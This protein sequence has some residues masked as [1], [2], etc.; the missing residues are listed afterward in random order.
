VTTTAA[1]GAGRAV[2]LLIDTSGSTVLQGFA[3]ASEQALPLLMD[4]AAAVGG[5]RV[6]L[7]GYGS[8]AQVL[9]RLAVAAD[10]QVIP[11]L[12]VSGLSSLA[13]A[14]TVLASLLQGDQAQLEADGLEWPGPAVLVL[15][16]GLPTDADEDL[17]AAR[18]AL[19]EIAGPDLVVHAA[20]P[21]DTDRLAI[22]GLRMRLH[23]LRWRTPAEG[24]AAIVSVFQ[25]ILTS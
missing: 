3:E 9:L 24:A 20:M 6:C 21:A 1:G 11:P 5:T 16:D 13:S 10:V 15:A 18:E 7:L 25:S 8:T 12:A 4:A 22:A 17:L 23:P 14:L 19:D 2:Y